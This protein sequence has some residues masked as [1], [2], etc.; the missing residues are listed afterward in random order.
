[1]LFGVSR[2]LTHELIRHRAGFSY[3]QLSQRFVD[4]QVLRFVERPEFQEDEELHK[5]FEARIELIF[6]HYRR[7]RELLEKSES[8]NSSEQK[9][10]TL[11][12]KTLNQAARAVLTNETESFIVVTGNIRSWRHFIEMRASDQAEPEIRI[13]AFRLYQALKTIEINLFD[14]YEVISAPDGLP[15]IKAQFCKV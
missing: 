5:E 11:R 9:S 3:S 2:S 15:A 14:D 13:L 1:L 6:E 7:L 12:R 8:I 4:H 10:K